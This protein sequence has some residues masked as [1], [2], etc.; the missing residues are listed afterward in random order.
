M[1][2]YSRRMDSPYGVLGAHV[3]AEWSDCYI[4]ASEALLHAETLTSACFALCCVPNRMLKAG[5]STADL[6]IML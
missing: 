1:T 2:A 3:S 4:F 6:A 5:A